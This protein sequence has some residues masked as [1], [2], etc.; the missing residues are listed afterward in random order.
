[1]NTFGEVFHKNGAWR[2][3]CEPHVRARLKR[4]FARAPQAAADVIVV[5][6]T[7]ENSRDLEWFL[8]RYPMTVHDEA[9]LRSRSGE[10][11]D[12][13]LRLEE[14][15]ARRIPPE[16]IALALP[17]RSYQ[18]AA[19]QH[20][21]IKG[22]LLLADDLGL[23]KTVTGI[24]PM[25]QPGCLPVVVVCPVHLERQWE[26]EVKR[27]A[28]DLRVHRIRTGTP[29]ALVREKRGRQKDLWP[30][31]LPDV[32]IVS[33]HKLRKW[34]DQL[35]ELVRYVIFDECQQLRSPGTQIYQ[36]CEHVARK[37]TRR[38]GLSATPIYNYGSEFF[39]V[40]DALLPGALGTRDEFVREWCK[41]APGGN[42]RLTNTEEFGAYLR[43]EGIL[44]RRTRADV[45]RELPPLTR[46]AHTIDCDTK[47]IDSMAGDAAALARV[48][49]SQGE[50]YQGEKMNAAGEF[51]MLMRQATGIAKAPYVAEYVRLMLESGE[52]V[53]LFGWHREVYRIWLERL[54]EYK[55]AMYTGTES[56]V[57]KQDSKERFISGETQLL[58]MSLRSG[59]GVDGLQGVCRTSV[60][61]EL[62]WS[63]GVLEQ[64]MGRMHRDGQTEPCAAY[65]LIADQGADPVMA[66][67]LGVKREQIEGVR[68]PGTDLV[69]RIDTGE[70]HIRRLARDLLT[71]RGEILPTDISTVIPIT[72]ARESGCT[73]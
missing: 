39:W 17:P 36:A 48:I 66:E 42:S 50:R 1:M 73:V 54:A 20:L 57:Q 19:A 51:D 43:R 12:T 40:I 15:L 65:Y 68:N 45:G 53:V 72:S 9:R 61:G 28:P 35:G 6:D 24:C 58:I 10:H 32:L 27:F 71:R 46:I 59:A 60:F 13:E 4:V 34:A 7:P 25:V 31:R 70:D 18:V 63:P 56:S 11:R 21:A 16:H 62:D 41:P 49:L 37:A 52:R 67:I 22:G 33:Y 44:L 23:G 64:C 47:V 69:E 55:P 3:R 26:S 5:S 14:L 2:I 38:L 8:G 29:Y 30:E